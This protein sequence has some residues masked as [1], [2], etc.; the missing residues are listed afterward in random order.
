MSEDADQIT[1][2][3][4]ETPIGLI[5]RWPYYRA[6]LFAEREALSFNGAGFEVISVNPTLLLGPGD[7]NRSSTEDVALF[8][9]R[10][11]PAIP[12]GGM[13][14]VDA[15]DAAEAL[16]LAME[17]GTPGSRYLVGACNLTIREFFER[18]ERASG[19]KG[20]KLPVPRAPTVA[21]VGVNL[22]SKLL[23]KVN[24]EM[25]LP[26]Q[27][28]DMAQFYW[29]LDSSKAEKELGWSSREPS[30]TIIDTIRD[31]RDRGVG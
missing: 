27:R 22:F 3:N 23:D 9:E 1:N 26:P 12:P 18:L 10:K 5:N 17:K 4:D 20:P 11:I 15:R 30:Q 7:E 16:W 2:E 24:V 8:L 25:P 13:S 14:F 19:V 29:Y 6:K 21:S 31:L 28:L